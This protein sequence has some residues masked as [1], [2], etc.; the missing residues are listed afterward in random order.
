VEFGEAPNRRR[1][2]KRQWYVQNSESAALI[3]LAS[4]F[5]LPPSSAQP[6]PQTPRST[7]FDGQPFFP[8]LYEWRA[9]TTLE[10]GKPRGPHGDASP[11]EGFL[12]TKRPGAPTP[13]FKRFASHR[14]NHTNSW[15][16][17]P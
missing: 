17:S 6:R 1:A 7:E 10:K 8:F 16:I 14:P 12:R 4:S 5:V 2:P 13:G 9:L 3:S 15:M 11:R